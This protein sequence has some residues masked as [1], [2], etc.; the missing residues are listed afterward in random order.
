MANTKPLKDLLPNSALEPLLKSLLDFPFKK[1][2]I[3]ILLYYTF[4][5]ERHMNIYV[6][7]RS[8]ILRFPLL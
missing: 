3:G 4:K 1:V 6:V 8:S 2:D 5:K 7:M